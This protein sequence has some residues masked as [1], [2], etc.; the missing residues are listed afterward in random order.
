MEVTIYSDASH[1]EGKVGFAFQIHCNQFKLK[2]AGRSPV[3]IIDVPGAELLPVLK[4]LKILYNTRT[5]KIKNI[6]VVLDSISVISALQEGKRSFK[7]KQTLE[8]ADECYYTM[9]DICVKQGYG[10]RDVYKVFSFNHIKAHTNLKDPIS[11][12]NEWCDKTAK[13]HRLGGV[14]DYYCLEND[15][16]DILF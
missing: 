14:K 15:L 10:V 11:R 8:M 4:A 16:S 3:R 9:L 12:I 13:I 6:V 1:K 2:K 5:A 7:N